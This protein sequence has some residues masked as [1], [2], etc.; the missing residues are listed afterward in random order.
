MESIKRIAKYEI[1][2]KAVIFNHMLALFLPTLLEFVYITITKC[3]I[4]NVY[5]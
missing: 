2:L 1:H 5:G 3:H 4:T